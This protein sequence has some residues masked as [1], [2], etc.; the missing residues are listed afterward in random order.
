VLLELDASLAQPV[1]RILVCLD[2]ASQPVVGPCKARG[3]GMVIAF[4][5][6]GKI[7]MA[8]ATDTMVVAS[9]SVS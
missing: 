8:V 4:G 1:E 9:L 2:I 3:L 6:S 5:M 7:M